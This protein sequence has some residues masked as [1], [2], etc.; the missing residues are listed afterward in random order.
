MLYRYSRGDAAHSI[1][2]GLD[3]LLDAWEASNR[4]GA[5]VWDQD[6]SAL[7]RSWSKNV[8]FYNLSVRLIGLATLLDLPGTQSKRLLALIADEGEDVILDGVSAREH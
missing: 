1:T 8:D 2:R 6:T 5:T 7:R 3:G 4:C